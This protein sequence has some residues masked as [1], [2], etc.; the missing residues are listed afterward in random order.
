MIFGD[1][2]VKEQ[3]IG[4]LPEVR[5]DRRVIERSFTIGSLATGLC[6]RRRV[7]VWR[8]WKCKQR[9]R[10]QSYGSLIGSANIQTINTDI[11]DESVTRRS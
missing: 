7:T 5:Y 9:P 6:E 3:M 2:V 4:K 1:S 11:I 8:S 10:E